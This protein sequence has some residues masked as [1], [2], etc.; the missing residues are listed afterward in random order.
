[1]GLPCIGYTLVADRISR[2]WINKRWRAVVPPSNTVRNRPVHS[3][4]LPKILT[5]SSEVRRLGTH[6]K[7]IG[8]YLANIDCYSSESRAI[9]MSLGSTVTRCYTSATQFELIRSSAKT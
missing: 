9:R 1:M 3:S 6:S 5:L 2:P 4:E 7:R 8:F